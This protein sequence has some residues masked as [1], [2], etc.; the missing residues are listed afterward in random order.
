MTFYVDATLMIASAVDGPRRD[1][2]LGILDAVARGA[3]GR[4]SAL[5]LEQVWQVER[6]GRAGALNG[7]AEHAQR[8]FTPLLPVGE[9]AFARALG[10]H[11][12]GLGTQE[13]LH[14]GTCLAHEI[15]TI[16]SADGAYD[17]VDGLRRVD[18]AHGEAVR[19]LLGAPA[20]EH[21]AGSSSPTPSSA[22]STLDTASRTSTQ[23]RSSTSG[24]SGGS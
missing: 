1:T 7:L 15:A 18:P 22:S 17:A 10:L 19:R 9:E 24:A 6:S 3:E 21:H 14:A 12:P 23:P 8:I 4:T 5:A 20:A 2:C 13:R 16:V 11:A